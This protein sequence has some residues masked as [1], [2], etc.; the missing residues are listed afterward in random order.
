MAT[1]MFAIVPN[2]VTRQEVGLRLPDSRFGS[3]IGVRQEANWFTA[4]SP[5]RSVALHF[6]P[7]PICMPFMFE[8]LCSMKK[9]SDEPLRQTAQIARLWWLAEC[10]PGR[11]LP[12]VSTH[13]HG[14]R[15][16]QNSLMA[17]LEFPD[18]HGRS[19]TPRAAEKSLRIQD[20]GWPGRT[21]RWFS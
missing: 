3:A 15:V 6:S 12:A 1:F 13:A 14:S 2:L 9:P 19:D 17:D 18:P 7:D 11:L 8:K 10:S 16:L 21:K 4:Q 5:H 20:I